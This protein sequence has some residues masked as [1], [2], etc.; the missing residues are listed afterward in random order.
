MTLD[1]LNKLPPPE[2]QATLQLC[3]G[4][5]HWVELMSAQ[6]PMPDKVTL[7]AAAEEHWRAC[8]PADGLE[9]FSHHP[10]IGDLA[11]LKQKWAGG[12]QAS[13][14]HAQLDTLEASAAGNSEY[15]VRFGY[16]FIV[17]ATGKS[18]AEM[19]ELLRKRLHNTPEDEIHIAMAEQGKIT[20]IR[21]EKLL[22]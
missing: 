11:S 9:A 12:E 8:S 13:I 21:L 6:F 1:E 2:L 14:T 16:I 3:N 20:I 10:R 4:S 7:L 17:N 19:L 18:A 15:E 5:S 22:S